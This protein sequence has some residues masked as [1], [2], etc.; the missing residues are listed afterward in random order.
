MSSR[1]SDTVNLPPDVRTPGHGPGA[2]SV[3]GTPVAMSEQRPD[4]HLLS[5]R[6]HADAGSRRAAGIHHVAADQAREPVRLVFVGA[7]RAGA[8][9]LEPQVQQVGA[10][11]VVDDDTVDR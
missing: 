7:K 5:F 10:V 8:R 11:D 4:R 2:L 3:T 9:R 1:S 6:A